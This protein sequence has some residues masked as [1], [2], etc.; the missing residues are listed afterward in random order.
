[1]GKIKSRAIRKN[2]QILTNKGVNFSED[3]DKNKKILGN[4]MIGKKIRN[5]M[6][7]LL[8]KNRKQEIKSRSK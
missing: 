6:A 2:A 3:F 5:Q 4:L 8:A 1:M 7:G